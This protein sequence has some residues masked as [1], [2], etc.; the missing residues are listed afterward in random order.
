MTVYHRGNY[1]PLP[2]G[3]ARAGPPPRSH[4]LKT[5]VLAAHD[6]R[7][8]TGGHGEAGGHGHGADL[9]LMPTGIGPL[10]NCD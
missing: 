6:F 8:S 5:F 7:S 4:R 1:T 2:A 3:A 10:Q 9:E